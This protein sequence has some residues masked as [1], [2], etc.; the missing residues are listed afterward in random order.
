M[1]KLLILI[2]SS[3]LIVSCSKNKISDLGSNSNL[4]DI[5]NLPAWVL[6]P[7]D[8]I[9]D[10]V[11]GV[12]IAAPSVGGIKFQ[13]PQAETDARAN[14]ATILG[15]EITRIT[16]DALRSAKITGQD[17][18]EQV[19]TQATKEVVKNIPLSG[20]KRTDIYQGKDGSLYVRMVLRVEDYSKYLENSWSVY[21]DRLKKANISRS[22]IDKAEDATKH[23]FD[24][25]ETEREKE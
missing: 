9:K 7:D 1:K 10:G 4:Q 21:E 22:N 19:F 3:L 14:I 25:L 15:S 20:A 13:I 5:S 2:I 17:D 24:E 6:N 23:L 11:A 16:K 18:V 8:N 12:G